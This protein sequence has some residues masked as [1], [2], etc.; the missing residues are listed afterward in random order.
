MSA[1]LY[2][3][4]GLIDVERTGMRFRWLEVSWNRLGLALALIRW[5]DPN[6]WSLHLHFLWLNMFLRLPFPA[7]GHDGE[8]SDNWGFSLTN[9]DVGLRFN[10]IHLNWHTKTKII[11]LPW[12]WEF[13]S[14][15]VL[16][17]AGKWVKADSTMWD[18]TLR[19]PVGYGRSN[20]GPDG[21]RFELLPYHY[22]LRD[23]EV[24]NVMA[25]VSVG[26]MEWRWR[27]LMWLPW[28]AMKRTSIDVHFEHQVGER[29]GSWKGGCTGCGYEMKPGETPKQC[30]RRMERERAFT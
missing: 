23:D 9:D 5:G 26:R 16:T 13:H 17:P 18:W 29:A 21:R 22:R 12:A 4:F 20:A 6:H 15:E 11:Y 25:A 19:E 14:H 3:Y 7:R 24:Q 1:I 27:W 2:R 28:P 10:A 30:L 8:M